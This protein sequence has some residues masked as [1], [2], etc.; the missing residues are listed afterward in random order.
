V[1]SFEDIGSTAL[2]L[3]TCLAPQLCLEAL[4]VCA[5]LV[6]GKR[7]WP[8]SGLR[9]LGLVLAATVESPALPLEALDPF[10]LSR[11]HD[12]TIVAVGLAFPLHLQYLDAV[13]IGILHKAKS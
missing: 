7:N 6:L 3:K 1:L 8:V 9:H 2:V 13:A 11:R 12:R 4:R 10:L 5:P